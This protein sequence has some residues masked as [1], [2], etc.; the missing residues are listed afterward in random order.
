MRNL[1]ATA[2]LVFA[3][4]SNPTAGAQENAI[5]APPPSSKT[6][7]GTLLVDIKP[8]SSEKELPKKVD[9]QLRS[10][11]LEWGIRDNLIVF[12]MVNKQFI[13]FPISHLTRY[14]QS[15][16]LTLPAGE[17]RITGIGMEMTAGFNVQK[18]LDRG[19][20]VN[21]DVVVFRIEE[22]K[23]T[24]LSINPVIK[25]DNAFVVDFW[26]PTML[27]SV[28]GNGVKGEEKALNVRGDA[29]IAWPQY[30]G[31]LKFVAK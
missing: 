2:L 3:G 19:A 28:A 16:T 17:Y 26:M 23:A 11:G 29:S 12:T 13:D 24:T 10:G 14:G 7:T 21:N 31:S 20:F 22:G 6:G 15:E 25:K 1:L 5:V 27:A 4:L 8:F 30:T 18:I 9:K